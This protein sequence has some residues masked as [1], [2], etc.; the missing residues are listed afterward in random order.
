MAPPA[1]HGG[2]TP[3]EAA[4]PREHRGHEPRRGAGQPRRRPSAAGAGVGRR[5]RVDV[6]ARQHRARRRVPRVPDHL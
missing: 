6:H 4:A 1:G 2:A 3:R 5:V